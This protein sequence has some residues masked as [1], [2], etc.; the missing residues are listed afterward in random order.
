MTTNTTITKRTGH[1]AEIIERP[2][3]VTAEDAAEI[4]GV[5]TSTVRRYAHDGYFR[6]KKDGSEPRVFDRAGV[7]AFAIRYPVGDGGRRKIG[8]Q[9]K[10]ERNIYSR[11]TVSGEPRFVVQI[12]N[13]NGKTYVRTYKTL[14][15]ARNARDRYLAKKDAA[16]LSPT[17]EPSRSFFRRILDRLT[18]KEG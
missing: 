9:M 17:P 8:R 3:W 15:G 4:L 12:W 6:S 14:P 2:E 5:S 16:S 11:P 13:S 7:V 18:G 1:L 10:V